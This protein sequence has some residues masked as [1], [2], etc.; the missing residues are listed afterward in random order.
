MC[1]GCRRAA[2]PRELVR[3]ARAADGTVS[4]GAGPGRGAWL[5]GPPSTGRC[6]DRAVRRRALEPAL[7]T[8]LTGPELAGLRA[9]LLE[10]SGSSGKRE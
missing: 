9:K 10:T 7:R 4:V 2:D 6:F 1:V 5:C 3:I 8:K